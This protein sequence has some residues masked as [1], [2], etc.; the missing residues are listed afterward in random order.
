MLTR[1]KAVSLTGRQPL[2]CKTLKNKALK[3]AKAEF[4]FNLLQ[5][6]TLIIG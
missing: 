1:I 6:S 5:I 3:P 2:L 4:R